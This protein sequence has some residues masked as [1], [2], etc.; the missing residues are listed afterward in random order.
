V[1]DT[2]D[3][4]DDEVTESVK[5]EWVAE[6]WDRIMDHFLEDIET[7]NAKRL[8][9]QRDDVAEARAEA[10]KEVSDNS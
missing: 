5:K 1:I 3:T 4:T 7:Y 9:E 6:N 10:R 2:Q 8:E